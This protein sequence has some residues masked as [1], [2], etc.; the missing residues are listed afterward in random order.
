[1]GPP[2]SP[3]P[4][5]KPTSIMKRLANRNMSGPEREVWMEGLTP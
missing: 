3:N 4:V 5:P 2:T 1:M